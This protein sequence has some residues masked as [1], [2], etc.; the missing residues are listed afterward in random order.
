MKRTVGIWAAV[1]FIVAALLVGL[2]GG[3]IIGAVGGYRYGSDHAS[4]K[5]TATVASAASQPQTSAQSSATATST[6]KAPATDPT[7]T[8][9]TAPAATSTSTPN[10][11]ANTASK[12]PGE[13]SAS[14]Q[15]YDQIV[16]KVN[17]AVVTVTNHLK[18]TTDAFGQQ[19]SGGE[20]LGTG[21][22]L[23]K[24]GYIV[25][26]DHVV[27]GEASL[28]VTFSDGKTVP[29][30]LVGG[31]QWQDVAVIKVNTAVPAT[32]TW[33]NSSQLQPGQR[34]IAI[35]S[36]LGQFNNTVTDGIVSAINRSLDTGE[37]YRL[38]N[39]VQHDA[40]INHG[41]SGGP[42]IN[43]QGQVVGMNTALVSGTQSEPAQ[44]LGFAIESN[45]VKTYAEQI[46]AHG[47]ITH[48]YL[49]IGFQLA[50]QIGQS[51]TDPTLDNN[52]PQPVAIGQVVPDSP[53]SKAGIQ[54]GDVV[55]KVNGTA[56]TSANPFINLMYAHKPGDTVTLTIQRQN[57]PTQEVKVTLG[58]QPSTASQK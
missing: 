41:N 26:N 23:N 11:S 15:S 4:S 34:V 55:T 48:P 57:G 12:A 14:L 33:G 45:T 32:I 54:V 42:L 6:A 9:T 16:A 13:S 37:G 18:A 50:S 22:I 10:S 40:T 35:G 24:D 17:P 19:Q 52:T 30:T 25:T 28:Q 39:L 38:E 58:T 53:A 46:I 47:S 20:A 51:Q 56:L 7:P 31:D 5:S 29:A 1:G 43:L 2:L 21:M 3:G 44:G 8:A 49:G 27:T 36:A